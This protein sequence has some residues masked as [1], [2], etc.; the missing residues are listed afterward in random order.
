MKKTIFCLLGL[1]LLLS[2]CNLA[3]STSTTPSSDL[4][5]TQ[6]S[7]ALTSMPTATLAPSPIVTTPPPATVTLASQPTASQT[8]PENTATAS[9]TATNTPKPSATLTSTTSPGDPRA[10]LGNPTWERKTFESGKDFGY[11]TNDE[12]SV[13]VKNGLLVITAE[14]A[15]NFL[16]W[17]LTYPRPQNFYLEATVKTSDCSG[18]D[19]YGLVFRANNYDESKGYFLGFSC[20]GKYELLTWDGKQLSV[21]KSWQA[22]PGL[23]TGANQTNRLGVMANGNKFTVYANGGKLDEI[24]DSTYPDGGNFGLFISSANTAGFNV[25]LSDIAYWDLK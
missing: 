17:T 1:V 14:K 25:T 6:V 21:V 24:T 4:I 2:A 18:L 3:R 7:I 23:L 9:V 19:R 8:L 5:A 11:F 22:A 12:T 13:E 20:D 16:G 15:D 10:S